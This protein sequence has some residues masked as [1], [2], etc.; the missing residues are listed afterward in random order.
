MKG[1]WNYLALGWRADVKSWAITWALALVILASLA[2][3]VLCAYIWT[4][5]IPDR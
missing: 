4:L 1:F 5:P 2:T 3:M